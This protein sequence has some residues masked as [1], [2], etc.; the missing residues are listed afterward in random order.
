MAPSGTATPLPSPSANNLPTRRARRSRVCPRRGRCRRGC[1]ATRAV[2]HR[3][4]PRPRR[5]A[6]PAHRGDLPRA[7][8]LPLRPYPVAGAGLAAAEAAVTAYAGYSNY[9]RLHGEL[10]WQTPA[11]RFDGTPFTDRGFASVPA[12]APVADLLDAILA[13]GTPVSS[14]PGNFTKLGD[15]RLYLH[16]G[17]RR[18][19]PLRPST[20]AGRPSRVSSRQQ[21][22]TLPHG[23]RGCSSRWNAGDMVH[24][25]PP[26]EARGAR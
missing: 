24:L 21:T 19:P 16:G 15:H 2:G 7:R 13:A 8:P 12:L 3:R 9:H 26:R 20:A 5:A 6:R 4:G 17:V 18:A 10:D 22:Q 25:Q 14:P 11:E 1:R 23:R